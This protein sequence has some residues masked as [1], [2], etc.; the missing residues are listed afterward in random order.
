MRFYKG[1]NLLIKPFYVCFKF[2]H[3]NIFP[4]GNKYSNGEYPYNMYSMINYFQQYMKMLLASLPQL[5]Q[6]K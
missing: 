6:K 1:I 2:L 3:V 4:K 5:F